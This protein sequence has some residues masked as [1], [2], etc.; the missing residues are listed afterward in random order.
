MAKT[1]E[2]KKE[3]IANLEKV[4][5]DAV[6]SVFVH[7][8]GINVA[9]ETAMRKGFRA[10]AIGYTV[11]KKSL[12]RRALDTLGHAHADLPLEGELAIAYNTTEN[13]DSTLV[14]RKV[15]S[16]GKEFG[17]DKI[18][19]MGGIFD[20]TIMNAESM[21]EIAMIPPVSVLRGMFVNVINSPIQRMAI[22]L[23][24]IAEKK[25]A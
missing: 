10:E 6:S 25:R 15:D 9:Q 16:F 8:R 18:V 14:A 3:V 11:A 22:A 2:Q 13:A 7:F 19:I 12:L 21:R 5:K 20:G 1:K 24:Q 17:V 23:S 4:M